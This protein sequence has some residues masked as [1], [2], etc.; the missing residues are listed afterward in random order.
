MRSEDACRFDAAL[1]ATALTTIAAANA[2]LVKILT[3]HRTAQGIRPEKMV[4]DATA[5]CEL[6]LATH[7]AEHIV[8]DADLMQ[9]RIRAI[10]QDLKHDVVR[11]RLDRSIAL[12]AHDNLVRDD[13][14]QITRREHRG[15]HKRERA[16]VNHP[17]VLAIDQADRQSAVVILARQDHIKR[18]VGEHL[19]PIR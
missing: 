1:I 3:R 18:I 13:V 16:V 19:R 2:I 8:V 17:L 4:G 14:S 12:H 6:E 5:F 15:F 11:A 9:R 10:E 7:A